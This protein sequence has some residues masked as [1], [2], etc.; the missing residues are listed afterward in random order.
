MALLAVADGWQYQRLPSYDWTLLG[1][2]F[3]FSYALLTV[4]SIT[5]LLFQWLYIQGEQHQRGVS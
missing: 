1:L 5:A 3:K 2:Y 4:S